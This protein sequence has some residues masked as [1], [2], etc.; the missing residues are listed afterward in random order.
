MTEI[1][2]TLTQAE[3]KKII[4]YCPET[5]MFTRLSN[6]KVTRGSKTANGYLTIHIKGKNRYA[7]RIAYLYMTGEFPPADVDHIDNDRT[8]N[9]WSNLRA[10][11][12]SQNLMNKAPP[13]HEYPTGV[14][15]L[16]G[17]YFRARIKH[18]GKEVHGGYFATAEEA[19]KKAK[20]LREEYYGEYRY[21]KE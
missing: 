1:E 17:K 3:I 15:L 19:S 14:S 21:E 11:T 2:S 9:V 5:G 18:K 12:R 10:V 7:H 4:S 8:N 16:R 6:G 20:Q 13:E